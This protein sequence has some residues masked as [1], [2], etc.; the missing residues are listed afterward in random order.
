MKVLKTALSPS[1]S[2]AVMVVIFVFLVLWFLKALRRFLRTLLLRRSIHRG[3]VVQ[4]QGLASFLSYFD[5]ATRNHL[6]SIV[7][8]RQSKPPVAMD[9]L[10]V[11]CFL[12]SVHFLPLE[13]GLISDTYSIIEIKLQ[14]MSTGKLIL[15]SNF[16]SNNFQN[17]ILQQKQNSQKST[18]SSKQ[19]HSKRQQTIRNTIYFYSNPRNNNN[20]NNQPNNNNNN[21]SPATVSF[22]FLSTHN[23]CTQ[24]G[25]VFDCEEIGNYLIRFRVPKRAF[26]NINTLSG[27]A[28]ESTR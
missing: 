13:N 5:G 26:T 20:N 6:N 12:Q 17:L 10:H 8:T 1:F 9:I 15:L 25:L 21:N 22:T 11:P 4:I 14:T 19:Y 16:H 3:S 28:T 18:T 27:A 23:V 7:Q 2:N 24:E